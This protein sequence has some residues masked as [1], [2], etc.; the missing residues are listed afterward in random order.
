[1][2]LFIHHETQYTYESTA[3]HSIQLLRLTPQTT[4]GQIINKWQL[5]VPNIGNE[6]F[7]GY[8]NFCTIINVHEPHQTL[9]FSV[10]GEVDLI[11]GLT[12]IKDERNPAGLFLKQ[13]PLTRCSDAMLAFASPYFSHPITQHRLIDFSH[14]LLDHV[15]YAPGE[16]HVMTTADE[17][18]DLQRGVCQDHTHIFLACARHFQL[19]ARYVSG[20]LFTDDID[21]AATHAWAEVYLNGDW[22]VFDTSNRLFTPSQHIQL[23]IGLDY[24]DG[25]PIRGVRVGGGQEKMNYA[26]S[27]MN[28]QQ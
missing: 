15:V 5:S 25:A 18:F 11:Y 14:A 2:N 20:Y 3:Q 13:T 16:T 26:V 28:E 1:M 8:G 10:D 6:F 19:P 27:V 4:A 17:A 7:D 23:A 24:N 9:R 21:H 12:H 22:Y